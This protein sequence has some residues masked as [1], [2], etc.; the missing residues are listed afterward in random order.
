[1]ISEMID[2]SLEGHSRI[3]ALRCIHIGLLCVQSDP[4]DRPDIPSIIFMLNRDDMALQP[5]E[6][7]AFFF[8]ENSNSASPPCQQGVYMYNRSEVIFEDISKNGLTITYPYPR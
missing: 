3:Q 5:P 6:Q 2:Q 1:M 4:D 7:P 8:G